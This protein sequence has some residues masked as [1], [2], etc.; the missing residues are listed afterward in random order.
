[1]N[2]LG[3][4][5]LACLVVGAAGL[6]S[7]NLRTHHFSGFVGAEFGFFA[8]DD[9]RHHSYSWALIEAAAC[10]FFA[11]HWWND[12]GDDDTKRRLRKWARRFQATRRTAPSAA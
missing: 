9:L 10:A 11:W 1:M 3:Y 5:G 6:A 12:G 2:A 8:L 7:G 4:S